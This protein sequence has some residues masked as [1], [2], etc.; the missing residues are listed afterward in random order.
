MWT[1]EADSRQLTAD[2]PNAS[3]MNSVTSCSSTSPYTVLTIT[4]SAEMKN[5]AG[6]P[7]EG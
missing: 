3:A 7:G 5:V 6:S 2:S 4:P 1:E